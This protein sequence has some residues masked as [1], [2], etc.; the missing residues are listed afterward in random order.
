MFICYKNG[1]G[2]TETEIKEKERVFLNGKY[3]GAYAL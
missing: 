3:A 2:E 1:D